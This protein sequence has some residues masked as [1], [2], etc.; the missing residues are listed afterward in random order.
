MVEYENLNKLNKPFVEDYLSV[1]KDILERGHL[2]LGDYVKKIRKNNSPVIAA[3][4][5][6]PVLAMGW[7]RLH[8]R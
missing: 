5:F 4:N 2:I 1:T 6:V 8:L 3:R 7:M